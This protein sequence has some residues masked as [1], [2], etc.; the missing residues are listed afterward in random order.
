LPDC[1][2]SFIGGHLLLLYWEAR[3]QVPDRPKS[4]H[5]LVLNVNVHVN[6]NVSADEITNLLKLVKR[7]ENKGIK[8]PHMNP[9][10]YSSI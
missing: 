1:N 6:V 7:A 8:M 9:E 5:E 3:G 4:A 2:K 10:G